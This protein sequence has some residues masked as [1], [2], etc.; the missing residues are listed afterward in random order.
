MKTAILDACAAED[1]FAAAARDA[2]IR[3]FRGD[4]ETTVIRPAGRKI[5]A[6]TG[7]F[8]CWLR[9]P[10][11]CV[12]DDDCRPIT[13]EIARADRLVF[14]T[15]VVFGGYH[16]DLKA[17][18]ERSIGILTPFFRVFRGEMHHPLRAKDKAYEIIAVG[19]QERPDEEAAASFRQ[20]VWRNA[21]NFNGLRWQ[22][23][24]LARS[25]GAAG[26]GAAIDG[27]LTRMEAL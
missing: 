4:S 2:L 9:T 14:F 7:C 3:R 15:P 26:V 23:G 8:G 21:L 10:G 16:P 22:A 27:I 25:E 6:C 13:R 17:V 5:A 11:V 24:C 1:S 20:R 18:M 19:I 12:I